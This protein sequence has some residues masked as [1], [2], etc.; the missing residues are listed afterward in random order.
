MGQVVVVQMLP[1]FAALAAQLAEGTSVV[2]VAS[3]V[4]AVQLLAAE[5]MAGVQVAGS[6]NAEVELMVK[7]H[8]LVTQRLAAFPVCVVQAAL[9]TGVELVTAGGQ[10]VVT[11]LFPELPALAAQAF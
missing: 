2:V 10:V 1:E 11:Q 7:G 5:A 4:V 8:V 6:R 3:H 9:S